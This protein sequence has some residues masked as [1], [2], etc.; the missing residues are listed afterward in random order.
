MLVLRKGC[1]FHNRKARWH[2]EPDFS[3][4]SLTDSILFV[5][6]GPFCMPPGKIYREGSSMIKPTLEEVKRFAAQ[7][8][9][10]IL[11]VSREIYADI[12]TPIEVLRILQAESHHCFLLESA[13]SKRHWGRY[14]FL[15]FDPKQEITCA[16]GEMCV[17]GETEEHFHTQDPGAVLKKILA[18]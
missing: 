11:P 9:Y 10:R 1:G 18:A 7:G 2:R 14:T 17:R 4:P 6:G 16:D 8:Q 12:K 13:E 15:G 5:L 3:G